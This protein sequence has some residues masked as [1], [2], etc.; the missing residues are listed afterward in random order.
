M[1][2]WIIKDVLIDED[3]NLIRAIDSTIR[4]TSPNYSIRE[5]GKKV[6]GAILNQLMP[7][8]QNQAEIKKL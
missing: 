2:E 1:T 3:L 7:D 8:K 5:V 4:H 6:L